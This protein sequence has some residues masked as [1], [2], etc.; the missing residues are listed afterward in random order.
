MLRVLEGA[1][2]DRAPQNEKRSKDPWC[3]RE[4][5]NRVCLCCCI[6]AKY[7]PGAGCT[8]PQHRRCFEAARARVRAYYQKHKPRLTKQNKL[9]LATHPQ[10]QAWQRS[11]GKQW[12]ALNRARKLAKA[13]QWEERNKGTRIPYLRQR[14]RDWYHAHPGRA[15]ATG[16]RYYLAHKGEKN[17]RRNELMKL[18]RAQN[19]GLRVR[20]NLRSRL[21]NLL[22]MDGR[23]G[24][25]ITRQVLLYTPAQLR[26]HLEQQFTGGM[27]W[28]N[29][30]RGGFWEV[31]H[32][33]PCAEFDLTNLKEAQRCFALENLRPLVQGDNRGRYHAER[34]GAAVP[35]QLK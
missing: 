26:Q 21:A 9:Y 13:R 35:G 5:Q 32:I 33:R 28:D 22:H 29:Y 16:Q 10:A 17:G 1:G 2:V 3:R 20:Y 12:Y 24:F 6:N 7:R 19:P 34:K 14:A 27:T 30:G 23:R 11:Y 31:D 8:S 18:A 4:G 15:R 25:S